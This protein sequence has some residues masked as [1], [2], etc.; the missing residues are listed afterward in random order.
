MMPISRQVGP[1]HHRS[2][3]R[4]TII[5]CSSSGAVVS[6]LHIAVLITAISIEQIAIIASVLQHVKSISTDLNAGVW[7]CWAS[8]WAGPSRLYMASRAATIAIDQISVV[9]RKDAKVFAVATYFK[10]RSF[11]SSFAI[12]AWFCYAIL[13]ASVSI[14]QVTVITSM[15]ADDKSISADLRAKVDC[16]LYSSGFSSKTSPTCFNHAVSIASISSI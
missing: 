4:I 9:T 2:P 16:G 7:T 15:P 1:Y 11:A 12:V 6:S 14:C 3:S 10:T 13:S 8:S 5:W